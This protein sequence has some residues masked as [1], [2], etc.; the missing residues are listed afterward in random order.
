[1]FQES[2]GAANRKLVAKVEV[3]IEMGVISSVC[4]E[5]YNIE[6]YSN[7]EIRIVSLYGREF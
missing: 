3:I 2:E 1:V 5:I 4:L 7:D 6:L